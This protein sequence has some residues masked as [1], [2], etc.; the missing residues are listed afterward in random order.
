MSKSPM[1]LEADEAAVAKRAARIR[2]A[3]IAVAV[4]AIAGFAF[5][6]F[7]AVKEEGEVERWDL[8][9]EIRREMEPAQ[10]PIWANPY[11]LYN[12]E[13][14]RYIAA[15][16]KFLD[17]KAK[18]VQDALEPQTRFMIAKIVADHLL[19]NP[20]QL[21]MEKRSEFYAKGASQLAAL[22]DD[23]PDFPLNWTRLSSEGFP[24]LTRQFLNW[25]EENE[26]WEK[27]HLLRPQDPDADVRVLFRTTRGDMLA[28]LYSELAPEWSQGFVE[29]ATNGF[30]DGTAFMLKEE[31]GDVAEP[32]E[33]YVVAGLA[34][35]R[36][37][38][39][40]FD[41]AAHQKASEARSRSGLLP[42]E[43]RNRIPHD[44]GILAAW[45]DGSDQYDN[46]ERFIISVRRSPRLDYEY[47][48]TGKV[49]DEQGFES[50]RVLDRI[51]GGAVWREDE[52]VRSDTDLS[53]L[54]SYFQEP[55]EII[56]VLVYKNGTLQSPTAALPSKAKIE[57]NER[58]LS[59][60]K[61]DAFKAE[62]KTKPITGTSGG[63][64]DEELPPLPPPLPGNDDDAGNGDEKKNG[65]DGDK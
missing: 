34:E 59:T 8:F 28:G 60:I 21:D 47:S 51:F 29:R 63:G 22:R 40:A 15:L 17:T 52:A 57:D 23:F 41:T 4:L 18:E 16:E 6:I 39:T 44:R 56:K 3:L 49:L 50:T 20:G 30:Y 35:S 11:G 10:D 19:A 42:A 14:L 38:T 53:G 54:L 31:I 46:A 7:L 55:V 36:G 32:E 27:E 37:N 45:H 43:S 2:V 1:N 65:A 58:S 12:T 61:V 13:R 5:A 9:G 25:F 48:P 24:S 62:P 33:H 26:K 64:D